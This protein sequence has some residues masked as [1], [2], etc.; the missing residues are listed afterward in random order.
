VNSP[1]ELPQNWG[2]INPNVNDYHSDPMEISSTFW[3]PNLTGCWQQREE[4][5][6]TNAHLSNV[7][8][9]IFSLI[10]HGV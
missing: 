2:Q 3:L 5:H 7:A 10:H 1:S 8:C 4:T 6:S 9:D